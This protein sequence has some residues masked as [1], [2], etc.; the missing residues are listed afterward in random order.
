M[1]KEKESAV[2][3]EMPTEREGEI[4]VVGTRFMKMKFGRAY[5]NTG[6]YNEDNGEWQLDAQ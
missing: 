6:E 5:L 4:T 2:C 3:E 1:G